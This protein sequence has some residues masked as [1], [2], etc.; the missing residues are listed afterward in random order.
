M[1]GAYLIWRARGGILDP[2]QLLRNQA[3]LLQD[4][5]KDALKWLVRPN[6]RLQSELG[7]RTVCCTTASMYNVEGCFTS[8]RT[9]LC[10]CHPTVYHCPQHD[11][12]ICL[13]TSVQH[14]GYCR[15]PCPVLGTSRWTQLLLVIL[16]Q[17]SLLGRPGESQ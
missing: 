16:C 17:L 6:P 7:L 1:N 12:G 2:P 14:V 15:L 5:T 9:R 11:G 4:R 10:V 8:R 13:R 3:F